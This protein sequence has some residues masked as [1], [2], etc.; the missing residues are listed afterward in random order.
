MILQKG[1]EGA[2]VYGPAATY[3]VISA[4]AAAVAVDNLGII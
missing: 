3:Q 4:P 1:M 2:P